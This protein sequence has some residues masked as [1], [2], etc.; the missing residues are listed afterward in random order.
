[1][2]GLLATALLLA[3]LQPASAQCDILLHACAKPGG[4]DDP[5][6][7]GWHLVNSTLGA[8]KTATNVRDSSLA[9]ACKVG[10]NLNCAGPNSHCHSWGPGFGDRNGVMDI[11]GDASSFAVHSWPDTKTLPVEP[12][13]TPPGQCLTASGP[14][15]VMLPI[16]P[17]C[18]QLSLQGTG[19]AAKIIAV[20]PAKSSEHPKYPELPLHNSISRDAP[21]RL[22]GLAGRACAWYTI[23]KLKG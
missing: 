8:G 18:L 23:F 17:N 5:R 2:R 16:G 3:H 6:Q 1:M 9:G 7:M 11:V 10:T 15:V 21:E 4:N 19:K 22:L 12:N 14:N 20:G 13:Q